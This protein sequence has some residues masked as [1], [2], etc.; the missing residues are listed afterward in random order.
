MKIR[1][2]L[3]AAMA[4]I[5][6]A[7]TCNGAMAQSLLFAPL[8]S[9]VI[10]ASCQYSDGTPIP[11][12]NMS[13]YTGYY[14]N[15]GGHFHDDPSHRYS[16]VT[17]ATGTSDGSGYLPITINTDLIGQQEA[18]EVCD[19]DHGLCNI[20]VDGVGYFDF[21]FLNYP[22]RMIL[23]GG[24][25]STSMHGDNNY[26]HWMTATAS[27]GIANAAADYL[28]VYNPGGTICANDAGLLY[29]GK[30]DINN[31]WMSPHDSHDRGTAVD[32]SI[33]YGRQCP[34]ASVVANPD[35]FLQICVFEGANQR[36]SVIDPGVDVHC[37]WADPST[38]PH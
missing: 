8:S 5:V 6:V 33:N 37:N 14:P 19:D 10:H 13:L 36:A 26:N 31:N 24:N 9:N 20:Y 32:I 29:G 17:P 23:V 15:T 28:N 11:Y 35:S 16:S 22:D 34:D 27:T 7:L 3:S 21:N 12:C 30:F 18:I 2:L 1:L 38:Y 25:V 4:S